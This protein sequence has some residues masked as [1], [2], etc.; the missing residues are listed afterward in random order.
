MRHD[1]DYVY[2]AWII[3][4]ELGRT[5]TPDE[6]DSHYYELIEDVRQFEQGIDHAYDIKY[7]AGELIGAGHDQQTESD[8]GNTGV[9]SG[10]S[11]GGTGT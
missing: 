7:R 5:P 6:V 4:Q 9:M 11:F 8:T 2:R 1:T 10:F 3:K